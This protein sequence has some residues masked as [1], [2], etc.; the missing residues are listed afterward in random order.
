MDYAIGRDIRPNDIGKISSTLQ[1][2]CD[3][4]ET[5]LNCLEE[6]IVRANVN[7]AQILRHKENIDQEVIYCFAQY[8]FY[9]LHRTVVV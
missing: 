4:C 9:N 3:S 7:K 6:Q 1:E 2:W 8:T 5:V